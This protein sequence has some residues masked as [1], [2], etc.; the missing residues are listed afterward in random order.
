MIY[1]GM[2]HPDNVSRLLKLE[3]TQ[4]NIVGTT[5]TNSRG[6]TRE[7]K[8]SS[9]FLSSKSYVESK[10][11]RD[12]IDW[13]L[14]KLNQSEIGLKQLQRT[15]GISITLSCVWRSKFGHSGPVLWPEQMRS[16]SDLDLEC[17]FDIYF[18]PDK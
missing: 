2:M 14:R 9:W 3:P 16:I 11:L 15:E 18:D 10:D 8:L 5:V 13:L 17:S 1:P 4:K 6:K 12:H 7:I